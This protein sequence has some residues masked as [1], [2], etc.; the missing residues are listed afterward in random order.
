MRGAAGN[1]S[2]GVGSAWLVRRTDSSTVGDTPP[3]D[4]FP[5]SS[6]WFAAA[7]LSHWLDKASETCAKCEAEPSTENAPPARFHS[8]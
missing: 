6:S 1:A 3:R 2:E 7:G 5:A 4:A 8:V